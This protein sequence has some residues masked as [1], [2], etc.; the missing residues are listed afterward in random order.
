MLSMA[1]RPGGL[2]CTDCTHRLRSLGAGPVPCAQVPG[3]GSY[4]ALRSGLGSAQG[5]LVK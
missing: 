5:W 1:P 2:W 4:A 3:R